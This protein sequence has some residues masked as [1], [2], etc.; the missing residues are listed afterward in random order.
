[1]AEKATTPL[2]L[3]RRT[4]ARAQVEVGVDG[5]TRGAEISQ[6]DQGALPQWFSPLYLGN[7]FLELDDERDLLRRLLAALQDAGFADEG[8]ALGAGRLRF[9]RRYCR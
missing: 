1:M 8:I 6:L 5:L 9:R 7:P 2:P 4:G 3:I